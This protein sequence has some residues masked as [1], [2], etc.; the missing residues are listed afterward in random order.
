MVLW[1]EAKEERCQGNDIAKSR[2]STPYSRS[3]QARRSAKFVGRWGVAPDGLQLEAAIR[4]IGIARAA[5]APATAGREPQ[6]ERDRSRR[7]VGQ[8]HFAGS[9][10]KKGLR[11]AKRREPT[12]GIPSELVREARQADQL[13]ERRACGLMRITCWSNLYQNV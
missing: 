4:R 9:A 8:A 3:R 1:T 12:S 6:A 11:P 13:S 7:H 5:G 2:S 10:L